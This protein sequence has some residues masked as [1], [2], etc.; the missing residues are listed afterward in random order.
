MA[1]ETLVPAPSISPGIGYTHSAAASC[2]AQLQPGGGYRGLG[3]K[4]L[5]GTQQEARRTF[6]MAMACASGAAL[7]SAGVISLTFLSVLCRADEHQTGM[8]ANAP[9]SHSARCLLCVGVHTT[10]MPIAPSAVHVTKPCRCLP[11]EQMA[12]LC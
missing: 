9:C 2:G 6:M 11:T 1:S 5:L 12:H 8:D 4:V 10:V 7:N 3:T